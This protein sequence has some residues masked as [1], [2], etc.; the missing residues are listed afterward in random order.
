M[1]CAL[2]QLPLSKQ[3]IAGRYCCHGCQAVHTIL[4]GQ[5]VKEW[6]EHPIFQ[7]A[8]RMG[9]ISNPALLEEIKKET[10]DPKEKEKIYLEIEGMWC[11]S[12]AELL[13]WYL[14][15]TK[16][17]ISAD[18]DYTTDLAIVT[19][20]PRFMKK[21]EIV[22]A[23]KK[24]GYTATFLTDASQEVSQR[25]SFLR[26]GIAAFCALNIMMF[27][28]P[29]YASYFDSGEGELVTLFGW[30][31][32]IFSLPVIGYAAAPILRKSWYA[33]LARM[34]G[35]E[36]LVT[37]SILAAFVVSVASLIHGGSDLYF[38]SL[39]VIVTFVLLGQ[40]IETKAK[41]SA[42]ESLTRLSLRLPRKGRRYEKG[43]FS[44]VLLKEVHQGDIL[45]A[46]SG[47]KIVLDGVVNEGEALV[48]ESLLT[49]EAMPVA[50][51]K[52]DP[53][54]AGAVILQG[55]LYYK[56]THT[57]RDSTLQRLI[58]LV[59]QEMEK[60]APYH[61][62]IDQITFWF[63][64]IVIVLGVGVFFLEGGVNRALTTLLIAC[65]C[66][67]GIAAP[68]V[69]SRLM[70]TLAGEGIIVRNRGCLQFLGKE[71]VY[72]FDKTGT[73]TEGHFKV[74]GGIP[75]DEELKK[76]LK[77]LTR[78][79]LHPASQAIQKSISASPFTFSIQEISGKGV[80]GGGYRLGS[81]KWLQEEGVALLPTQ[82][83]ETVVFLS[84]EKTCLAKIILGD[85]LKPVF[86]D[87]V[88]DLLPTPS[89]LLSGDRKEVVE[90][91]AK[92]AH[93]YSWVAEAS[94]L[95]KRNW[96]DKQKEKGE[97]VCAIGDGINDAPALAAAE[98]GISVHG[99][100][101]LTQQTADLMMTEEK[102]KMLP[103]IR[104]MGKKG[105][106]LTY[107]NIFW[108]FIYNIVGLGLA[109]NG[110]LSPIFATSAMVMSSLIVITNSRRM[111]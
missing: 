98:V 108:A 12:C 35:M 61:R 19:Y 6:K 45:A 47:E 103:W 83:K 17:V 92:Q 88:H 10:Q 101:D 66:A 20:A 53:L 65:P 2:C 11:P 69:E 48:D 59:E 38:D 73:V 91:I 39:S 60:K 84:K 24:L 52:G 33:I 82:E 55:N 99:A 41:F 74:L 102:L 105:R 109:I 27:S 90:E 25:F 42:K 56:V 87:L 49:G 95:E 71:T 86:P 26:L 15:K 76:I 36:T 67:I 104:R 8:Y 1:T 5:G 51:K 70:H 106:R 77:T 29:V 94:P 50:K 96:I 111:H 78:Y 34:W 58:G 63:V 18:I 107:Q 43:E 72:V 32:A 46:F 54:S 7:E 57:F 16:G 80:E 21:E 30:L 37:I 44:F 89:V 13:S 22:E 31:S 28:Y 79:S 4:E 93:M 81:R 68:L 62:V 85:T 14:Q 23:V 75:E 9:L 110:A 100:T 97:I 40:I 64:P 3:S